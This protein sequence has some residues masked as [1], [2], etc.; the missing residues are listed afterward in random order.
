MSTLTSKFSHLKP[1]ALGESCVGGELFAVCPR[2]FARLYHPLSTKFI[3]SGV[4]PIQWAGGA[5]F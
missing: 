3:S 2:A 4:P 5:G 1:K